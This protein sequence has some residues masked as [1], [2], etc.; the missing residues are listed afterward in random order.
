MTEHAAPYLWS[1]VMNI[2][3]DHFTQK[4]RGY[5]PASRFEMSILDSEICPYSFDI[6]TVYYNLPLPRLLWVKSAFLASLYSI[7]LNLK[8]S[9]TCHRQQLCCQLE[10]ESE[11]KSE[12]PG[13]ASTLGPI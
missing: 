10:S 6:W 8:Y 3:K 11:S 13:A 5:Y 7:A 4:N 12:S 2:S 1:S 9:D